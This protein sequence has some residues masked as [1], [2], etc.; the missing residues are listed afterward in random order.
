MLS[1]LCCSLRTA[2][3]PTAPWAPP[4]SRLQLRQ[5]PVAVYDPNGPPGWADD[6]EY[7]DEEEEWYEEGQ[8]G[9]EDGGAAAVSHADNPVGFPYCAI[10]EAD[11]SG[12]FDLRSFGRVLSFAASRRVAPFARSAVTP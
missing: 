1:L 7:D 9:D 8:E 11:P 2:R 10:R 5:P 6:D 12:A 3:W 4:G